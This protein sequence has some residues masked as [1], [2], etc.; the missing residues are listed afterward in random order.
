[1]ESIAGTQL[2]RKCGKT[3]PL[4]LFHKDTTRKSGYTS[5]CKECRGVYN[6]ARIRPVRPTPQIIPDSRM[7]GR[8]GK[9]LPITEFRLRTKNE[10]HRHSWCNT[11]DSAYSRDLHRKR[12]YGITV[13]QY[14]SL[15]N[16]QNGRCAI[17]ARQR[18]LVVDHCHQTGTIRG[19]LCHSCNTGIGHLGDTSV[20]LMRAVCY[21]ENASGGQG[22]V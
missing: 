7:C 22:N 21:L 6:R 1:M 9:T 2:C 13:E 18:R 19:L 4:S 3:K 5:Q 8:C 17:C 16:T 12:A 14:N 20:A 10:V 11:C 15:Y